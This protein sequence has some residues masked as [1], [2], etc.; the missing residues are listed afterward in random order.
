MLEDSTKIFE[1]RYGL[2]FVR[3]LGDGKD[4]LVLETDLQTAVKFLNDLDTYTRELRAYRVL[5]ANKIDHVNG[6]EVPQFLNHD[7][8]LRA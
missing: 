1:S 2:R 7:D 5:K 3:N 6:Y 8:E 4:G